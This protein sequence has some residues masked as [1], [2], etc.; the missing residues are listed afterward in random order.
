[1]VVAHRL[2]PRHLLAR[3]VRCFGGTHSN[4]PLDTE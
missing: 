2:F 3:K 4:F 1:L